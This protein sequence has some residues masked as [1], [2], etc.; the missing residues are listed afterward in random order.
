M[1]EVWEL[2]LPTTLAEA[3]ERVAL[4]L[5]NRTNSERIPIVTDGTVVPTSV[6][7]QDGWYTP[8]GGEIANI[9]H[10]Y[11]DPYTGWMPQAPPGI[12]EYHV[13]FYYPGIVAITKVRV[14]GQLDFFCGSSQVR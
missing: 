5:Y 6:V 10:T 13:S 7:D 3:I 4:A 11:Y 9:I 2:P 12:P 14:I 8:T 1:E